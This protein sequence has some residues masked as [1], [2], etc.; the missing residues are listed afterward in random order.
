MHYRNGREAREGDFVVHRESTGPVRSGRL[1]SLSAQSQTC[2]GQLVYPTFTGNQIVTINIKDCLH[3][4]DALG[5]F[6]A[7]PAQAA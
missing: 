2:N 6:V 5:A 4:E 7:E 3:A 1:Q